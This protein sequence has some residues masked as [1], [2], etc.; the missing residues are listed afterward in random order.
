MKKS[1]QLLILVLFFGVCISGYA[2]QAFGVK[3]AV[4]L[5]RQT[6]PSVA[7]N[8][9]ACH[10]KNKDDVINLFNQS[11]HARRRL[12]C[13]ACHGGNP[14]ANE[15]ERAHAGNFIGR[16]RGNQIL[17]RCGSCHQAQLAAFRTSKHIQEDGKTPRVDCVQCHG[18]HLIGSLTTGSNFALLCSNCHGL[19]YLPELPTSLRNILTATDEV[20][21]ALGQYQ[22]AG[23]N[24]SELLINRR[25]EMRKMVAAIVH[26]TSASEANA[27]EQKL[28]EMSRTLK[29]Q[30]PGEKN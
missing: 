27:Q 3:G 8:C 24:P 28:L 21:N 23:H 17:E 1:L 30:I 13:A 6:A 5:S 26:S 4:L 29:Q 2:V 11:T 10:Q 19:E 25:R 18:A 20:K 12:S 16:P 7:D 15:R 9:L 14:A 22:H